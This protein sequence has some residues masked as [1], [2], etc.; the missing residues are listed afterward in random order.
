MTEVRALRESE[1]EACIALWCAVW[2]GDSEVYFRRYLEGDV[3]WLPYYTQV[4]VENGRLLS[5]VQ[6]CKRTVACG[7]FRLQMGGIANVATLPEFR[8]RGLGTACLR[9]AI[10]IMEAD[11]MDFSLLFGDQRIYVTNGFETLSRSSP[12]GT[13]REI[14]REDSQGVTV[15]PVCAEDLTQLFDVYTVYNAKRPVAVNRTPAYWRDWI[16]LTAA[17]LAVADAPLAAFDVRGRMLAYMVYRFNSYEGT[18]PECAYVLEY[19]SCFGEGN[20]ESG[21]LAQISA[22]TSGSR[23]DGPHSPDRT[24]SD[25]VARLLFEALAARALAAGKRELH[26]EIAIDRSV[27]SALAR[28]CERVTENVTEWAMGRLLHRESL[29]RSFLMEW[30]QRWIDAGRPPGEIGFNTPY[31]SVWLLASGPFL[32]A[33]PRDNPEGAF[34][35]A[36]LLGLMFGSVTA[37]QVASDPA[38]QTLLKALFPPRD[39]VYWSADDF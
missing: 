24:E 37:D 35:Q 5:A 14:V 10:Q 39:G 38:L 28:V 16:G 17:R 4:A 31:G 12:H 30:N 27:R 33:E 8:R 1:K 23:G 6:I 19:G 2:P 26:L 7:D 36:T 13:L 3:E 9:S 32:K 15:R 11:A 29:V 34:S 21:A 22:M 18:A 25:E 20:S